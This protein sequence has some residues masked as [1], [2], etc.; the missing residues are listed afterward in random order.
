[1]RNNVKMSISIIFV[2]ALVVGCFAAMPLPT[3]A[4]PTPAAGTPA[5][6]DKYSTVAASNQRV[7][8]YYD[9]GNAAGDKISSNAHSG[10][11]P[12][13]YFRWD[14]KQKMPGVFLVEDWVFGLFE[15]GVFYLTAKTSNSYYKYEISKATGVVKD[16]VYVYGIPKEVMGKDNKGKDSPDTLKNINMVFIDGQ[17]KSAQILLAKA[18]Y[19][20]NNRLI[21]KPFE[22]FSYNNKLEF[23]NGAFK[24]GLNEED[25]GEVK[26]TD[27]NTAINGKSVTITET[28]MPENFQFKNAY[29]Y[30]GGCIYKTISNGITLTLKPGDKAAILFENKLVLSPP[31]PRHDFTLEKYVDGIELAEWYEGLEGTDIDLDLLVDDITFELWAT[32]GNDGNKLG[33]APVSSGKFTADGKIAFT[34]VKPGWYMVVEVL[35]DYAATIFKEAAPKYIFVEENAVV[36]DGTRATQNYVSS[37]TYGTVVSHDG[38]GK[39]YVLPDVWDNA[40]GGN[41]NYQALKDMGA[42]WIWDAKDTYIYGVRGSV[43]ETKIE[44]AVDD[45][46]TVP[47]YFA[48]DNAAVVYVNGKLVGWTEVALEV[49]LNSPDSKLRVGADV[50]LEIFGALMAS[51]FDGRW[52]EGWQHAYVIYITLHKGVNEIIIVAAN[53]VR[54]ENTGSANDDYDDTN[55][56][57]GLI[58]G[59]EVPGNMIFE[60]NVATFGGFSFTKIVQYSG[61]KTAKIPDERV[62]DILDTISFALYEQ[63]SYDAR[64][65]I[66]VV[67]LTPIATANP[68]GDTVTFKDIPVGNY[69]L[70]E[71]MYNDRTRTNVKSVNDGVLIT[72]DETGV[73]G[74]DKD[75]LKFGATTFTFGSD[76]DK[77]ALYTIVNGY[78]DRK[79]GP[80]ILGYP[81]L[82]N[83]GDLFYIGITNALPDSDKFGQ[84]YASFCAHAGSKNFAGDNG[85]GCAGY[86]VEDSSLSTAFFQI[87]GHD[88]NAFLSALNYIEDYYG[89]LNDTRVVTQTVIWAL[90]GAVDINDAA[91][92][93]VNLNVEDKAAVEDVLGNYENYK[94]NGKI[95]DL[96]YMVCEKHVAEFEYCQPQLVP[97]YGLTYIN[98][99]VPNEEFFEVSFNKVKYAGLLPVEAG[100]FEFELFKFNAETNKY[101]IL[102]GTYPTDAKGVV[103]ATELA[104]GSYVF[105]EVWTTVFEGGLGYDEEGNPVENYNL[106]WKAIYPGE[107]ADGLYFTIAID[108][109]VTWSYGDNTVN[110]EIYGKHNVLWAPDGYDPIALTLPHELVIGL[111]EGNGKIIV[112]TSIRSGATMTVV[113]IVNPDCTR[114]GIVWIGC[115]DGTGT[116][117]EFGELC[118]HDYVYLGLVVDGVHDGWLWYG[119]QNGCTCGGMM[120]IEA[121]YALDYELP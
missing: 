86:M 58:F 26:I 92:N 84:E 57:C 95:V 45:S 120:T 1:M 61:D 115:S 53:S 104:P 63:K 60:N 19:D 20:A 22:V 7:G 79:V 109:E 105:K 71:I 29:V 31:D 42:Q 50:D 4:A 12:G 98:Y 83:A 110:N 28:K 47:F 39:V 23:N 112:I 74:L 64:G 97:I 118:K 2:L 10:D 46:V 6:D 103:T 121:W 25:F 116:G 54:T 100:E 66:P 35:G 117:I 65:V 96:V 114:R 85:L 69:Y 89:P 94:G 56:P 72:I 111:G 37:S 101:D 102:V 113:D 27:W 21:W 119:G 108:G 70:V 76:F 34:Q 3:N 68:V 107:A 16:G 75:S 90:L 17:Y 55:N 67:D 15:G 88:I 59:F 48:A 73:I 14:E 49:A 8:V 32:T 40:L 33:A 52:A 62:N 82:N 51:D 36:G 18:W 44:V 99:I 106:V 77:D 38:T 9:R 78:N 30:N 41:A 13:V 24:L 93:G 91:W 80:G 81:G 5:W 87:E 11:Y 43:F